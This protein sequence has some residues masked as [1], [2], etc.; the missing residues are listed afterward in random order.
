[1]NIG[2]DLF[3]GGGGEGG[4]IRVAGEERRGYLID[5]HIGGLRREHRGDQQFKGVREVE[6]SHGVGVGFTQDTV[7]FA[8]AAHGGKV[9]FGGF[10]ECF[11]A[12][13]CRLCRLKLGHGADA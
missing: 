12:A 9:T 6:F 1:M 10:G 5:A 11:R 13:A 3:F 2:F 8:G 7:D 4:R